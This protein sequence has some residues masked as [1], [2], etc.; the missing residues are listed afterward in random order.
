MAAWLLGVGLFVW[1]SVVAAWL[2][3]SGL[4]LWSSEELL[5]A[6]RSLKAIQAKHQSFA[7]LC[8]AWQSEILIA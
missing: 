4:V 3:D 7:L 8:F 5:T 6:E 2:L 1:S